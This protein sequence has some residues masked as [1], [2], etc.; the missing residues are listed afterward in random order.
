MGMVIEP[1]QHSNVDFG[2]V[3]NL[4]TRVNER[5]CMKDGNAVY[6]H[7]FTWV[8]LHLVFKKGIPGNSLPPPAT[9]H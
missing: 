4:R 9:T 5:R 6:R 7:R 2:P 1:F 3:R 8:P